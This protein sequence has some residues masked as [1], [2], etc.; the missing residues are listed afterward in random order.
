M[1]LPRRILVIGPSGSGKST[2]A[3]NLGVR[4]DIPVVHLDALHWGPN[5]TTRDEA[6]FQQFVADQLARE[7][8]V[9]DGNYSGTLN[10]RLPRAQAVIWLD[11]PRHIYF[12]RALWRSITG[13]G[14]D[15]PDIGNKERFEIA[16][17]KDW[18]WTYPR[19]SRANHA[20]LMAN[21]PPHLNGI[22]LRS[23]SEVRR[24]VRALPTTLRAAIHR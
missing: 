20:A 19:R 21:L 9:M 10:L 12:P 24:F 18:V 5:W 14:R 15:R 8:W 22:I 4:L 6:T 3:R 13:Y 23:P 17:F 1:D 11:L 16:F 7:A 2:L